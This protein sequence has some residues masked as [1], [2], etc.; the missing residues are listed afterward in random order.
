MRGHGFCT[1]FFFQITVSTLERTPE[2]VGSLVVDSIYSDRIELSWV[3]PVQSNGKILAYYIDEITTEFQ[4]E[5]SSDAN[6]YILTGKIN[7]GE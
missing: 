3:P 5:I 7:E 6:T 2:Q 1:F 4:V